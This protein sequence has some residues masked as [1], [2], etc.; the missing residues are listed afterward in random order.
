MDLRL[1]FGAATEMILP[2]NPGC[3]ANKTYNPHVARYR[4][5][6]FGVDA[7]FK[8]CLGVYTIYVAAYPFMTIYN[9]L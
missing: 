1:K 8:I 2:G 7:I 9:H 3:L 6:D 5:Y 4:V